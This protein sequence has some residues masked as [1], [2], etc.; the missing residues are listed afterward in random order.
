MASFDL[1]EAF[2]C[3]YPSFDAH[4]FNR[5]PWTLPL[6]SMARPIRSMRLAMGSWDGF[7]NSNP[8]PAPVVPPEAGVL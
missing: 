6:L 8:D 4:A 3:P 1:I 7:N 5:V 2:L